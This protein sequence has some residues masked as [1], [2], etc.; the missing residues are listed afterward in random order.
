MPLISQ[1]FSK[2]IMNGE[3]QAI[4]G[5]IRSVRSQKNHTFITINDGS[6]LKGIQVF[7]PSDDV[8]KYE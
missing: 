5:W 7:V 6:N 3:I 4:K 8:S 2:Q 1:I